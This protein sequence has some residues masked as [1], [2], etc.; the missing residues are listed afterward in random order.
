M[1]FTWAPCGFAM[2]KTQRVSVGFFTMAVGYNLGSSP[3]Y[4]ES[5]LEP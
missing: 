1:D 4:L 3:G 5:T 2:V